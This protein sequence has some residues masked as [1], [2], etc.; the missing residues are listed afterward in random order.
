ML[1]RRRLLI[2]RASTT[3]RDLPGDRPSAPRA[4]EGQYR[5]IFDRYPHPVWILDR[6]TLRFLDANEAAVE[7]NGYSLAE[8]LTMSYPDIHLADDEAEL[9]QK[10]GQHADSS[11]TSHWRQR[12]K[13]GSVM[14]VHAVWTPVPFNR[15]PA[16]L[17]IA[18]S[19]PRARRRLLEETEEGRDRL[20][21]LSRR[22]VE[23]QETERS[24]IARELHDEIGQLLTGLKL[25]I[26]SGAGHKSPEAA[27]QD[28]EEMAA[29]VSELIGRLRDMSMSLRPPMLDE[30]GLL[31]TLVW[32]FERYTARTHVRV[33][34]RQTIE[35]ARFPAPVEIAAFRIIQEALTNVARYAGVEWVEVDVRADS[36]N[37]MLRIEDRGQGFNPATASSGCSAGIIGMQERAHLVGGH[38]TLESAVAAGTRIAVALPLGV[39]GAGAQVTK[40]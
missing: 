35:G 3:S 26:A 34:L 25:L 4:S 40:P 1:L 36:E 7:R 20:L 22:L 15:V 30:I 8:F 9:R 21:A 2:Q 33:S 6:A 28:Q 27:D 31:P 23:I 37:L 14:S 13:S 29:I 38:L 18:E 24:E 10:L 5:S 39:P 32:H 12:A 11:G 17:M 19:T 16:I